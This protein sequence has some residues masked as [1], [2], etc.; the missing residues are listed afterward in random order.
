MLRIAI[1]LL[2][3]VTPVVSAATFE[4]ASDTPPGFP[5][6][7]GIRQVTQGPTHHFFGY[8]GIFPWDPSGRYLAC[9]ESDFA[10]RLVEAD[11]KARICLIDLE[12]GQLRHLTE[13]TSWNFQQGAMVHWLSASPRRFIFNDRVDGNV[14]GIVYDVDSGQRRA[15]D[16][17]V[18]AV[19][20]NGKTA[21]SLSFDRLR[22]TRP[23]YGYAGG[24]DP[25]ADDPHPAGDGLYLIDVETGKAKL[26]ISLDQA[27]R[28]EPVPPDSEKNLLWF[29]HVLYSQD[30][31]RIFFL[32]RIHDA[33]DKR[34]SAA[35]TSNLD[36][37]DLRCVLPYSWGA[38][39]YDWGAGRKLLMTSKFQAELP[40]RHV[41]FTDGD[42]REKYVALEHEEF[43]R[44]GHCHFSPNGKWIVTDS[45]P[46]QDR[47]QTLHLMNVQTKEVALLAK[48]LEPPKYKGDW[49]CDLHPRW[50]R[51]STQICID[52]TH[53]G[54]RQVY[55]VELGP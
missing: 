36:G 29:N 4:V 52:S 10:D 43:K 22:I 54:T 55:I 40:W 26:I 37:A 14:V 27:F 7:K 5:K 25:Y 32:A 51:D 42:P 18:A 34:Q 31:Q 48:F 49:R 11:D 33:D 39:H 41:L 15:L 16:R 13:T 30:D 3:A 35:F 1:P 44:D 38:S 2:W 19:A 21:I 6:V 24:E 50:S 9:L 17:P 47:M 28:A 53:D 46:R 20:R 12:T 8:Y 23:G 45:Y